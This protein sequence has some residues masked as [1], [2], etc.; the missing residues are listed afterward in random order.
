MWNIVPRRNSKLTSVIEIYIN[1]LEDSFVLVNISTVEIFIYF[2]FFNLFCFVFGMD[3]MLE[4]DRVLDFIVL[5]ENVH[6]YKRKLQGTTPSLL[7]MFFEEE[8]KSVRKNIHLSNFPS[9]CK[10]KTPCLIWNGFLTLA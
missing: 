6:V 9:T 8:K 10:S 2:I 4:T 7:Y 1:V 3:D 5:L